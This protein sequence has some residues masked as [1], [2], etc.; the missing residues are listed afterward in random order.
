MAGRKYP[1]AALFAEVDLRALR[2]KTV[3]NRGPGL[4]LQ[5][6]STIG[7][8]RDIRHLVNGYGVGVDGG[9]S[10]TDMQARIDALGTGDGDWFFGLNSDDR[11]YVR[12][13][14]N[15][16]ETFTVT[17]NAA[18]GFTSNLV[19]THLGSNVYEAVA[20]ADWQRGRID[21][22][23]LTITPAVSAAFT[24]PD[25]APRWADTPLHMIR[26]L[27]VIGDLDDQHSAD[28]LQALDPGLVS[29][30]EI[31]RW[32]IT[33]DGYVWTGFEAGAT[34]AIEFVDD[35]WGNAFRKLLGFSSLTPPTTT[36]GGFTYQIGDLIPP[37]VLPLREPLNLWRPGVGFE[38]GGNVDGGGRASGVTSGESTPWRC[39]L[40]YGSPLHKYPLEAHLMRAG[41]FLRQAKPWYPLTV[42]PD[43]GDIRRGTR[44]PD[45][46]FSVLYT[47]ELQ[48]RM[49]RRVCTML[50][51]LA[52]VMA[53][54]DG[55][56]EFE[57]ELDFTLLED[58][59][60]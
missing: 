54:Y 3:M 7:R 6:P 58:P 59:D 44:D 25:S 55:D 14:A 49:G 38:G 29:D 57:G 45:I 56:V 42:C 10:R 4:N 36:T 37:S 15:V 18:Y 53:E 2:S 40:T 43:I 50:D 31:C 24:I 5:L 26:A 12:F 1:K 47:G 39:Q 19:A 46:A 27:G 51:D 60:A 11:F 30:G 13:E 52:R 9:S 20:Q 41:G 48:G 16:G 8:F 32:G 21:D 35:E 33:D 23:R 34:S 28:C 22:V 17:A